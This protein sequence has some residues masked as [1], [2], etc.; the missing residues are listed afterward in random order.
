MLENGNFQKES[1]QTDELATNSKKHKLKVPKSSEMR[2][3]A[4]MSER[5]AAGV[6]L[7]H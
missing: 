5:G 6:T 4:A 7:D 3:S 1:S 2:D